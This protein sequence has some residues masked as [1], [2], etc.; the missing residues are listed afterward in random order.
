MFMEWVKSSQFKDGF[1]LNCLCIQSRCEF[2]LFDVVIDVLIVCLLI[3][4][5]FK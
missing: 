4:I 1:F 5:N 2:K 3:R